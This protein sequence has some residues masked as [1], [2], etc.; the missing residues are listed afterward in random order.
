MLAFIQLYALCA[1]TVNEVRHLMLIRQHHLQG[2]VE[3]GYSHMILLEEDLVVAPDFLSLFTETAWLLHA[4]HSLWC[5]SAWNDNGFKG[6]VSNENRLFR[7]DYFPGL[8][9][10]LRSQL[11]LEELQEKWP[12]AASTGWDHWMRV[13]STHK[14]VTH[15][16]EVCACTV[17]DGRPLRASLLGCVCRGV[18][19][20]WC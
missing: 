20:C 6:V 18:V 7:T 14:Y 8:G 16:Y 15:G 19:L 9:W 12:E 13:S 2:F 3:E 1:R 17:V 5:V 4:D 11:W 10:M